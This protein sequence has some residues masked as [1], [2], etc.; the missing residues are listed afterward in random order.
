MKLK[1]TLQPKFLDEKQQGVIHVSE[2]VGAHSQT[3]IIRN[4]GFL[5][6]LAQQL[7]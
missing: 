4:S 1:S 6:T 7:S 5:P 2:C 3:L